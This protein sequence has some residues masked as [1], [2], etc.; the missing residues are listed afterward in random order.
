MLLNIRAH[1]YSIVIGAH[2]VGLLSVLHLA[3]NDG[4]YLL[5]DVAEVGERRGA[6]LILRRGDLLDVVLR[7]GD[8]LL[9]R[10]FRPGLLHRLPPS[11]LLLLGMGLLQLIHQS[12]SPVGCGCRGWLHLRL[13]LV[14]LRGGSAGRC[15]TAKRDLMQ[16]P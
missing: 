8:A 2:Q 7:M 10:R 6:I 11:G 16:L 1:G 4:V 9:H 5:P 12:A 13:H 15:A 14:R 3:L